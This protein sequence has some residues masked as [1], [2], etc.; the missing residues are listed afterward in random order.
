MNVALGIEVTSFFEKKDIAESPT[1][2]GNAQI[3]SIKKEEG[4]L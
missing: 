1:V 2:Y 3:I 4:T